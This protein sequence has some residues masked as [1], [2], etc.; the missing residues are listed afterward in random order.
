MNKI[1]ITQILSNNCGGYGAWV[2]NPFSSPAPTESLWP[3]FQLGGGGGSSRRVRNRRK[4]RKSRKSHKSRKSQK[5]NR[6]RKLKTR[7]H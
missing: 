5:H 1:N 4:F 2:D 7:R 3:G 6:R